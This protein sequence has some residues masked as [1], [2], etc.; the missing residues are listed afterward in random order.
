V[1]GI[2]RLLRLAAV[3]AGGALATVVSLAALAPHVGD[4]FTANVSTS[5]EVNLDQLALRSIVYDS[6]GDQFD[7]LY[8][9]EN[10]AL[11]RLPDISHE[12]VTSVITVEDA[13]FW[14]HNGVDAAAIARALVRNV[15]AGGIEQ[16][17]STITQQLIKNGVV[18]NARNIDRKVPEAALA[19]RLEQQLTKQEILEAYLNTVYFGGGTYGVR[20]AAEVYFGVEPSNLNWGQSAL[21]AS[22]ISNP[23]QYDPTR[24]PDVAQER[25]RIALKL[26]LEAGDITQAQ[27]DYYSDTD[28]PRTRRVA[29]Q[30]QPSNYF[31]EEVRRE[32]LADKR[33]G[34]TRKEREEAVFGGGLRVYT[35]YDPVAQSQIEKAMVD[36]LPDDP[37]FFTAASASIEPGTGAVKALVGGPG[38]ELFKYDIAT[39]KGRPT[40]SSFKPFV[41]A[42]AMEKGFVP[43]DQVSGLSPCEFDNPGGEP[44]PYKASNF[45]GGKGAFQAIYSQTLASSNCAYLRLGQIVGLSNV[46][47][48]ASALGIS[49]DMSDLPLSMPLGPL[50]I[51]PIDMATAYAT[52]ANDGVH[53]DPIF[54]TRVEDRAGNILLENLPRPTRAITTQSARL[55]TNVLAANVRGGTGTR[56]RLESQPA[57]GKTGTAQ[58]FGDAWFVGF[59]PRLATAIWMGN[60]DA[61]VPMRGVAGVG[62]VTGGSIPAR[63][64]GAF[65]NAYHANLPV[66]EFNKP[67]PTRAGVILRTDSDNVK[68]KETAK[69]LCGDPDAELDTDDD[70]VADTCVDPKFEYDPNIGICPTLLEPVDVDEDGKID[71]CVTPTTTTTTTVPG[72]TPPTTTTV[73]GSTTTTTTPPTGTTTT[74]STTTTTTTTTSPPTPTVP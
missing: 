5:A 73:G 61:R 28:V 53:V 17:G 52:F 23:V 7:V 41:L 8:D 43:A 57:A 69:S 45:G 21:L 74:T 54:I 18:G 62:S 31:I 63:I 30:W 32:L 19:I 46:A 10:R 12:L 64:W 71:G 70:G 67:E 60:P 9:V 65:N 4:I 24:F 47:D 49:T 11:V 48:T 72:G 3:I 33:L 55:V 25:R 39:Q 15:A 42:A 50:D 51:T 13:G 68:Y 40:G 36:N 66:V 59:T 38:F 2:V 22:L 58:D 1:R 29:V 6:N 27:F 14:Q 16:G 26:L 35:T 37:R 20:A 44:N 34:L 56:A